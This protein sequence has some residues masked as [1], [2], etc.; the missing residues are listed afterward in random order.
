LF[1]GREQLVTNNRTN[2]EKLFVEAAST[3]KL[4]ARYNK[5]AP[6]SYVPCGASPIYK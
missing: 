2:G 6:Q 5:K 4:L 3:S 1:P